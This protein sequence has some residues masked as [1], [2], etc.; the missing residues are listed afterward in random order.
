MEPFEKLKVPPGAFR[1][2]TEED[3]PR[4][5]FDGY[6]VRARSF[7]VYSGAHRI[8]YPALGLASEA[9]EVAGK[10]AKHLRDGAELDINAITKEL[11]DVLWN[12]SQLA[13]DLGIKLTDVAIL[14]LAKLAD[15]QS[16][17]VIQGSGDER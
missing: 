2:A 13:S 7:A 17:G 12:L 4:T 3:W 8:I 5:T 6:Q 10:I 1:R 15:R 16:R 9:G 11:G 14:N